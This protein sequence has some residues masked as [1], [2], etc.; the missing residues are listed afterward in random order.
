MKD[1]S[2]G[3]KKKVAIVTNNLNCERHIQYFS[4]IEKYFISNGWI[5]AEDFHVDKVIICVCGFHDVMHE[6]ALR[7]IASVKK[8]HFPEKDIIIMGCQA[9][10]H[11]TE[12]KNHGGVQLIPIHQETVLDN[13]IH[14]KIPFSKII[15]N[16]IL[17]PHKDCSLDDNKGFFHIKIAQGC[18]RKCT[19]CVI[20]KAKGH[21]HSVSRD[22]IERQFRKAIKMGKKKIFLM[23]EDTF[24]YGIDIGTNIIE[25]SEFLLAIESDIELYFGSL[26]I[27]WLVEYADGLLSLC[28][29]G[30][31]KEL[32]IGLQHINDEILKKMGRPNVFAEVYKIIRTLRKECPNLFLGVDILVG[33]PG[34][35]KK[36]FD[37]MAEFFKKDRCFDK[38]RHFGF[39]D[40]KGAPSFKFKDKLPPSEI[41]IRWDIFN[42]VLKE[43]SSSYQS[44]EYN[45]AD[46]GFQLTHERDYSFCKNT[47]KDEVEEIVDT[48][49]IFFAKSK[50]QEEQLGEFDF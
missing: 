2:T 34:E 18:L 30:I 41:A 4:N 47:F 33:F 29:K 27:R 45:Q 13:I 21:I 39:S 25:L 5:V 20:N 15:P 50:I 10:T 23:G 32:H 35:T 26:H 44:S 3:R 48:P 37:E 31:T 36:I 6:K 22:E 38:V 17:I 8:N 49:G 24:A 43:R 28:K 42:G 40:V 16:N 11:E 46:V 1:Y 7:T 14:A 12:L 9:K 19:F